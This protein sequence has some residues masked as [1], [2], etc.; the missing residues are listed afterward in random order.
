MIKNE[1]PREFRANNKPIN[2]GVRNQ[3]VSDRCLIQS[4]PLGGRS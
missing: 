3:I 1:T 4:A 2:I